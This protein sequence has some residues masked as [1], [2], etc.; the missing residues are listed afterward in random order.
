MSIHKRWLDVQHSD[1]PGA[2]R[3]RYTLF[4]IRNLKWITK[5]VRRPRVKEVPIL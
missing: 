1:A 3:C 5:V 4:N 2:T